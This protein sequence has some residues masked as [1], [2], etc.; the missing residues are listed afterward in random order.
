MDMLSYEQLS[1]NILDSLETGIIMINTDNKITYVNNAYA[2]YLSKAKDELC[3][4]DIREVI[5]HTRLHIV[6]KSGIAE[7]NSW[8]PAKAGYLCGNRIP[9]YHNG[10][11]IGAIGELVIGNVEQIDKLTKELS[12]LESKISHLEETVKEHDDNGQFIFNSP[13]MKEI[14]N[15]LRKA[16]ISDTTVMITGETGVGK[17]VAAKFIYNLSDRRDKPFIK[18]NCAAIPDNLL[19]SEL[20]GYSKGAF[21]GADQKGKVGKFE[22]ANEGIIFLDEISSLTLSMQ[23]KLLRVLQEK[24]VEPI[25]GSNSIKLD[26]KVIAASNIPLEDLVEKNRFRKDL[27]YR[28]NVV[29]V[30]VPPLRERKEDIIPLADNFI[31]EFS[32]KLNRNRKILTPEAKKILVN[33]NW[34]GNVRELKNLIERLTIMVDGLYIDDEGLQKYSNLKN[35]SNKNIGSLKEE[36]EETERRLILQS[37]KEANGNKSKAAK[38]LDIDRTTL[39]SKIYKYNISTNNM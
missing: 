2:K 33:Y 4:K 39:Y 28:L 27:Y 12:F 25:G 20:F 18:I 3:G 9:I 23:S 34:P 7:Y 19:E 5:P 13:K 26:V 24:E 15:V 37:L 8:Q 17:E 11:I 32:K 30:V 10:Q 22:L 21:T 38:L 35:I 29:R 36:L 31:D 1:L 16:S 14:Y 6:C